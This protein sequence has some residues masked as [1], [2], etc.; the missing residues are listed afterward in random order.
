MSTNSYLFYTHVKLHVTESTR[1]A[2]TVC[3]Y[4]DNL[5]RTRAKRT[6]GLQRPGAQVLARVSTIHINKRGPLAARPGVRYRKTYYATIRS[7][8]QHTPAV[9]QLACKDIP[10]S[11][12]VA[13]RS[14]PS[15]S[16]FTED[17]QHWNTR[18]SA[19][20][21]CNCYHWSGTSTVLFYRI[22]GELN[23]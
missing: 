6:P 3:Y 23:M 9:A 5:A 10:R 22:A 8:G 18:P 2:I 21:I 17:D 11:L 19:L 15:N 7:K 14:S 1:S 4:L 20:V 12:R 13:P 16:G